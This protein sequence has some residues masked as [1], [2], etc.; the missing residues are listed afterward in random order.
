MRVLGAVGV[1]LVVADPVVWSWTGGRRPFAV[2]SRLW[3]LPV[4]EAV[5]VFSPGVELWWSGPS[6][7]F[8][9]ADRGDRLRAYEIVLR[10]GTPD[11]IEAVVD[12]ALLVDCWDELVV[13]RELRSAWQPLIDQA[14]G[15]LRA[16]S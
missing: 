12:G 13:H 11:A 2:P 3:R 4:S 1:R 14:R 10:E 8:E 6:R 16:V 7:R 15:R 5:G 9:L